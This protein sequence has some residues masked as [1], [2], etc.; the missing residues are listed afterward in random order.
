MSTKKHS[1]EDLLQKNWDREMSMLRLDFLPEKPKELI[2]EVGEEVI[3]GHRK[4]PVVVAVYEDGTYYKVKVDGKSG[5][6][7]IA[8]TWMDI[9]KKETLESEMFFKKGFY[10]QYSNA[11]LS[12]LLSKALFFGVDLAPDYQRGYV[13]NEEDK[14]AFI[15]SIFNDREIGRFLFLKLGYKDNSP[16]YEIVDGKQRLSTIIE[17]VSGKFPYRGKYFYQ[18]HPSDRAR[19]EEKS[20]VFGTLDEGTSK[21]QLLD[22]FISMNT[23]GKMM[24]EEHL[25]K[26]REM[27][28]GLKNQTE[29]R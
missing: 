17:F 16:S 23:H 20:V 26:V 11:E 24:S 14:L 5:E 19:M 18:L 1:N 15:E 27:K 4:N 22:I 8:R 25:K 10:I 6:E 2:F 12:S 29:Q 21:E 28:D 13:W 7:F 3:F 9:E